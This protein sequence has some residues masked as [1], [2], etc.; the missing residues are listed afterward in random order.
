MEKAALAVA[1]SSVAVM[2]LLNP[3][4]TDMEFWPL[5]PR[6]VAL[7]PPAEFTARRLRP[8]GIIGLQGAQAVCAFKEPLDTPVVNSLAMAFLEYIRVMLGRSFTAQTEERQKGD[9][10]GW[11]ERL[12][13]LPDMRIN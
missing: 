1:E 10:V 8:V 3:D 4:D 12:H 6:E 11:L 5:K 7:T 9:E 2:V 13:L